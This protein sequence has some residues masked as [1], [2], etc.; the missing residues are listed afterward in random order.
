MSRALAVLARVR[1]AREKDSL[2]GLLTSAALTA[3]RDHAAAVARAA[4]SEEPR[5]VDGSPQRFLAHRAA[6]VV[7]ANVLDHR[8]QV[9]RDSALTTSVARRRWQDDR[10]S[11][12]TVERLVERR[13]EAERSERERRETRELDLIA[14]QLH[15]R[16]ARDGEVSS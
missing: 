16:R 3:E 5:A 12:R 13:A 10:V 9:A 15:H 8:D 7:A 1:E 4:Y 11:L 6:L 14:E 2:V